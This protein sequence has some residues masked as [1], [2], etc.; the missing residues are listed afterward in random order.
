[1]FGPT[2][3]VRC[4]VV[5]ITPF[6]IPDGETRLSHLSHEFCV[7]IVLPGNEL[8]P[9]TALNHG[10]GLAEQHNAEIRAVSEPQLLAAY[11][12]C[13]VASRS[14]EGGAGAGTH[15]NRAVCCFVDRGLH[16]HIVNVDVAIVTV[17]DREHLP[18]Q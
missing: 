12:E 3:E 13:A 11:Y 7:V 17:G 16:V 14:N 9:F 6:V 10:V 18:L 15:R 8:N 2:V 5:D 4:K 1:M